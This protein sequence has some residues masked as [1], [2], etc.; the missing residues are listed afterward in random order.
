MNSKINFAWLVTMA[1]RDSRRNY[2]RLL[3]FVSSIVLGIAALVAIY[4]LGYNLQQNIDTQAASLLGAD[5][6]LSDN[7]PPSPKIKNLMD[8]LKGQQSEERSFASMI[9]FSKSNGTRLAQIRALEGDFP[10]YGELETEP[11]SAGRSFRN[12]KEVLVDQTLMLQY[13][14]KVGDSLKVGEVTFLIAGILKKAPGQTGIAATVAPSVY[15]PLSYLKQTNLAQKGSRITY[16]YYFKFGPKV[17]M[18]LLVKKIEPTVEAEDYNYRTVESQ[19]ED[20]GR[21]F[22]DL[23]RFLSLV[24][25]IALLLGCVGVAS[26]IHIY[27]REKLNSIAILRCLGVKASQ[28]FLIYLIQISGIGLIGSLLGAGLGAVIQQFLPAVLKDFLPFELATD[29]SFS[30]IGQGIV[31]GVI[32]SNLFAL[33]S[34]ISIRKIS[35]LNVLRASYEQGQITKDPLKWLVY[36]LILLFV[37]GF[38]WLQMKKWTDAIAFTVGVTVAFLLLLGMASLL[39][40]LVRRFF[41]SSWGYLGRQGLAN[42]YRPNN[43]TAILMVSIGLG[44]MFICTLLFVQNLLLD[45]IKLSTDGDQPNMVLFD[46]QTSQKAPVTQLLTQQKL[47]VLQSVPIVTMRLEQLNGQSSTE[48]LK[49]TTNKRWRGLFSREYRVTFRDSLIS[50]EKIVKGKWQG[51]AKDLNAVPI[52]LED[53]Y[54]ERNSIKIG[55]TLTFNVQGTMLTTVVS[56]LRDVDWA[57][58]QTNFLVVFPKGV[59]EEAPQFH[60]LLTH[61]PNNEVSAQ[62]QQSVVQQFPNISMIDLGLVLTVLDDI[63]TKIGFVIRFMAGFSILTGLIVLIASV[64]I[65]KYQ[66]IQESVLL[67]TLGASRR[68]ILVITALEYF[69]LGTLA[70]ATGVL[71]A[72]GGGW[73][74]ARFSFETDFNPQF[75]PVLLVFLVVPVITVFIGLVNSWGLLSRSPLEVLRQEV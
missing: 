42:L 23:T 5:L 37:F 15:I 4:S 69:F 61:V 49:D 75:L 50:S 68:Q 72:V 32:I 52:S 46:I 70:S 35:P 40:W 71:L 21:T 74:L 60:V 30:A 66:R 45:R 64:L 17:N 22:R 2:S 9:Y 3:L 65:S 31:L 55:D 38:T 48:A 20:T 27:I 6:E 67:R 14:A 8:S 12:K 53:G 19:K 43:Q 26:A 41:P 51:Q 47:P 44:T 11:A 18:P 28:A 57:G 1:W 25:F 73:A 59:L 13:Q 29:L 39:M 7:L 16:R 10:Y 54:A 34:L 58:V 63:S 56:S 36:G 33:L 24:G 62:F